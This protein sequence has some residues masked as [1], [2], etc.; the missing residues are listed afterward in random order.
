MNYST[1]T[2]FSKLNEALVSCIEVVVST[3][4]NV[5]TFFIRMK[6][7]CV[8]ELADGDLIGAL[9]HDRIDWQKLI[10]NPEIYIAGIR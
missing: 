8:S 7:V 2:F 1:N 9:A 3:A 6:G 10:P 4:A 5:S